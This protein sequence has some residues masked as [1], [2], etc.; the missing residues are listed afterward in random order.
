L[1]SKI[2]IHFVRLAIDATMTLGSA[3]NMC[4]SVQPRPLLRPRFTMTL[5]STNIDAVDGTPL[6]RMTR[7]GISCSKNAALK[8]ETT[9]EVPPS[10]DLKIQI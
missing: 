3:T 6:R 8:R 10:F 4:E 9:P 1:K 7:I 2:C 5:I